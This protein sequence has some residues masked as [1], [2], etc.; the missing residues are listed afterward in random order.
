MMKTFSTIIIIFAVLFA[1]YFA[2]K[3]FTNQQQIIKDHKDKNIALQQELKNDNTKIQFLEDSKK[4][5]QSK[6]DSLENVIKSINEK[7]PAEKLDSLIKKDSLKVYQYFRQQLTILGVT[8]DFGTILSKR[9]VGYGAKF[10]SEIPGLRLKIQNYE[11]DVV[12]YKHQLKSRDSTEA[13]LK[14]QLALKDTIISNTTKDVD[15]YRLQ[16][17]K[18]Q[19]F[20]FDRWAIVGGPTVV[21]NSLGNIIVGFGITGG[22]TFWRSK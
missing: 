13:L 8:P 3:T 12:A 7:K 1:V 2:Y 15:T 6:S 9:E 17:E 16:F 14:H 20:W 22:F 10:M 11:F 21:V 4:Y 19:K 5:Y 18:T